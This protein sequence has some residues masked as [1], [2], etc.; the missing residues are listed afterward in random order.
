MAF[1]PETVLWSEVS[2]GYLPLSDV[3]T[4]HNFLVTGWGGQW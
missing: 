2:H 3:L 4:V 1:P